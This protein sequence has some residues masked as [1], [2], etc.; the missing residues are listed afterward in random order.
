MKRL[1]IAPALFLCFFLGANGFGQV[2]NA[3]LSGTLSD[4]LAAPI[5]GADDGHTNRYRRFNNHN[6]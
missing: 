1:Y 5:P 4:S 6:K 3:T 2:I